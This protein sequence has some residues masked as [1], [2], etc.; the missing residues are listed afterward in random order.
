MLISVLAAAGCREVTDFPRRSSAARCGQR[1]AARRK[2][3]KACGG[4]ALY[5]GIYI[6]R[7]AIV[8]QSGHSLFCGRGFPEEG[9]DVMPLAAQHTDRGGVLHFATREEFNCGRPG[10]PERARSPG[11]SPPA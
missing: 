6:A 3:M 8:S 9:C 7:L 11:A 5:V 1:R 2:T 10:A 4:A